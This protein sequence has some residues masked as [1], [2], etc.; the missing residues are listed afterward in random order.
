MNRGL[1]ARPSVQ[2]DNIDDVGIA[3]TAV[4]VL[5]K[6]VNVSMAIESH[7]FNSGGSTNDAPWVLKSN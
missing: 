4:F 2:V 7:V 6:M 3:D 1:R 5:V